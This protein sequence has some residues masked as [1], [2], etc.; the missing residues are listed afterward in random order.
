MQSYDS[1]VLWTVVRF[2]V[3]SW[4]HG[5]KPTDPDYEHCEVYQIMASSAAKATKKAQSTRTQLVKKGA[6][7]PSQERPYRK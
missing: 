2:P 5:G 1:D 7:L 4:S 6:P 3:G